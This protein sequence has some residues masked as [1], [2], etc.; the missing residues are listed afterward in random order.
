MEHERGAFKVNREMIMARL[1]TSAEWPGWRWIGC[2][3]AL[4]CRE[5]SAANLDIVRNLPIN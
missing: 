3:R 4:W 5:R 1:R 2:F